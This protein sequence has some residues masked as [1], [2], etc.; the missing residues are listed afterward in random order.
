MVE[1]AG[2]SMAGR[3]PASPRLAG[4]SSARMDEYVECFQVHFPRLAGYC[5]TMTGDRH[6]GHE[7]AQ[8]AFARLFAKW[9]G[10]RDP[11]AYV[12]L[13]ATNLAREQW[14]R[15][16]TERTAYDEVAHRT[17]TDV[18]NAPDIDLRDAVER[19]PAKLREAVLLRY[20]ADLPVTEVAALMSTPEGTV[21]RL[22]HE[23]RTA[24]GLALGDDR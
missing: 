11:K 17:A 14:R 10:V 2:V 6:S 12:Y 3:V 18:F 23:A 24:L 20:Y 5:T 8:E 15:S 16:L 4:M 13:V 1:L 21:K 7:L 9:V 22:L 19:L